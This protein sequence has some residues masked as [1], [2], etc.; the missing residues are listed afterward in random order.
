[1]LT[2]V[3]AQL[4][5]IVLKQEAREQVGTKYLDMIKHNQFFHSIQVILYIYLHKLCADI[6]PVC[7]YCNSYFRGRWP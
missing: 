5:F 6:Y 1:M 4:L 2:A 3:R 7:K